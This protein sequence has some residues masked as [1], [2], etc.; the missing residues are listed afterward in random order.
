LDSVFNEFSTDYHPTFREADALTEGQIRLIS[1]LL[2]N[3]SNEKSAEH[4]I[5]ELA[6]KI[7]QKLHIET[8]LDNRIFLETIVKDYNHYAA[9]GV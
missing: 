1:E 9:M 2:E 7:K 4:S 8:S 6:S 5:A 3:P